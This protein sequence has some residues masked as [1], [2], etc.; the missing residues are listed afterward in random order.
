MTAIRDSI[1][2]ISRPTFVGVYFDGDADLKK[3]G[4]P[5]RDRHVTVQRH[6]VFCLGVR[7]YDAVRN[8]DSRWGSS[9]DCPTTEYELEPY[10]LSTAETDHSAV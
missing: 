8:V 6:V 7:Y 4:N 1:Q 10:G 3:T 5:Y 9:D 2:R